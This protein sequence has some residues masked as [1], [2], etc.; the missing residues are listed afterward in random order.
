MD[1]DQDLWSV[2]AL[3]TFELSAE[4]KAVQ[5][6][7]NRDGWVGHPTGTEWFC[8]QHAPLAK[9]RSHLHWRTALSELKPP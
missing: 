3:V 6:A 8:V 9:E 2:F 4:E 5:E 1:E 7:R